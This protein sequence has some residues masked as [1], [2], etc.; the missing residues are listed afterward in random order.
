M[1]NLTDYPDRIAP[2]ILY[3]PNNTVTRSIMDYANITFEAIQVLLDT[4][5][6][7]DNCSSTFVTDNPPD[8][9][10]IGQLDTYIN[11]PLV[12]TL[13]GVSQTTLSRLQALLEDGS[14]NNIWNRTADLH[15]NIVLIEEY[16][17]LVDWDVF[18]PV[19]SEN[20]MINISFNKNLQKDLGIS[21]VFA[22]VSH[23]YHMTCH[24]TCTTVII[25]RDSNNYHTTQHYTIMC[26]TLSYDYHVTIL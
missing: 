1:A 22:G 5:E 17:Y 23:D 18:Y 4:L 20:D 11:N 21:S 12:D 6:L 26:L 24:M 19:G 10:L 13:S 8:S 2:K 25:S 9:D 15:D 16:I 14:P 3:S 7:V